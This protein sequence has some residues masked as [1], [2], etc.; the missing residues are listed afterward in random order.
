MREMLL[1]GNDTLA[2]LQPVAHT[3]LQQ[4]GTQAESNASRHGTCERERTV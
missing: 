3:P 4:A 2:A 1:M